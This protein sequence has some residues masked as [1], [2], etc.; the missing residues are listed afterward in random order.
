MFRRKAYALFCCIA[1]SLALIAGTTD[2]QAET[3]TFSSGAAY[4]EFSFT[5]FNTDNNNT[6]WMANDPATSY[7]STITKNSG[8][9]TLISFEY[10]T[11]TGG[12]YAEGNTIQ[13]SSNLGDTTTYT[14]SGVL[15]LNWAG[16]TTLTFQK[17]AGASAS[18][19]IDDIVFEISSNDSDII[20]DTGFTYPANIAYANYQ[21]TPVA[22]GQFIL[23]AAEPPTATTLTDLTFTMTNAAVLK[24]VSLY[25]GATPL[26][27]ATV[28]GSSVSFSG[29]T[30]TAADGGTKTFTLYATFQRII[31]N[32]SLVLRRPPQ[33]QDRGL[34]PP[35]PVGLRRQL[36]AT[37]T[38]SKSRPPRLS[39]LPNPLILRLG[40]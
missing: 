30:L 33:G 39:L 38:A 16:I 34:Q 26:A 27:T 21:A 18:G 23:M 10:G 22:V 31:R 11:A 13:L 32:F 36:A 9:F 6:I 14:G 7:L 19:D 12:A 1:A 15:T 17:I 29:L 37:I 24:Q 3:M 8:K 25:D 4:P 28:T 35:M 2:V 20:A 40:R 5:G